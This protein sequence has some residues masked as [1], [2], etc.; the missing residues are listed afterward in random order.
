MATVAR[1]DRY[2]HFSR[3]CSLFQ[4]CTAFIQSAA[5]SLMLSQ[6]L[7]CQYATNNSIRTKPLFI[8][9]TCA[10]CLERSV[11]PP[12]GSLHKITNKVH[13]RT[14][15]HILNKINIGITEFLP[16]NIIT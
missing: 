1:I 8:L 14:M 10:E 4:K 7:A 12:T 11:Q 3:H 2:L 15:R 16:W 6:V 9:T 5:A 13:K